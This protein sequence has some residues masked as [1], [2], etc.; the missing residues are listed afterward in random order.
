MV[1]QVTRNVSKETVWRVIL[2]WRFYGKA[3]HEDYLEFSLRRHGKSNY[4]KGL[5]G[6]C[7]E[8]V[9]RVILFMEILW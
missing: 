1:N 4:Q 2:L 9:W 7:M 8:T 5:Y 6:D 3:S